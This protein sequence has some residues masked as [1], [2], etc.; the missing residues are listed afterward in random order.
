VKD[1]GGIKGCV[2]DGGKRRDPLYRQQR[3]ELE[4]FKPTQLSGYSRW[5]G[6]KYL[7]RL[8]SIHMTPKIP[9]ILTKLTRNLELR[10][11]TT[12]TGVG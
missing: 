3:K 11:V 7:F 4:H 8:G 12:I 6:K 2:E 1:I 10:E 9:T 5:W